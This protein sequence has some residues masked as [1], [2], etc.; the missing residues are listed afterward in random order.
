MRQDAEPFRSAN[1]SS[2]KYPRIV[3]EIVFEVES[4]FLT[5]HAGILDVPGVTIEA[6]LQDPAALSQNIVPD[7]ARSEIGSF[8]F[9]LVDIESVFTEAIRTRLLDDGYGLRGKLVR[10]FIGYATFEPGQIGS[11]AIPFGGNTFGS[12]V[13]GGT[14]IPTS[15]EALPASFDDFVVF[16]TQVITSVAYDAGVYKV[17]CADITRQQREIIFEP[18]ATTLLQPLT[19]SATSVEVAD[20]TDFQMIAHGTSYSD[21]P[22]SLVGYIKIDKEII[23][24]TSKTGGT[25]LGC[26]RGALNTKVVAHEFSSGTTEDR[27][28]KV[29]EYIY[30]E[31]PLVQIAYKI[32]TGKDPLTGLDCWP[33]HWNVGIDPD[34]VRISDFT[35]IGKDVWDITDANAAFVAF[36]QGL[37]KET[38]K[39]FLESEIYILLGCYSP[40]YADGTIG[41]KR[42]NQ[43]LADSAGVATLDEDNCVSWSELT[44]DYISMHNRIRLDWNFNG[45]DFTRN[46][47]FIDAASISIHGDAPVKV[48]R[49]KGLHGSRHTDA[50]VR[51]RIDAIRDRYSQPPQRMSVSVLPSLNI[52]EIGDIAKVKLSTVRDFAA[53][54]D[55]INRAF[56]IQQG[57]YNWANG[58]VSFTMF[59]STARASVLP[60]TSD[61]FVLPDAY[62]TDRGTN[63]TSVCTIVVTG[64]VGVIQAGSYT[65]TGNAD[66]NASAA[67]FYYDGN[68]QLQAGA[69]LTIIDNV[70][71]RHK[72]FF[73]INGTIN[74]VGHG[75]PGTTDA[76]YGA[77]YVLGTPGFIGNSRA[78][79]GIDI[80]PGDPPRGINI[81]VSATVGAYAAFPFVSL[82]IDGND[83]LGIPTDMRGT[84]CGAGG[85]ALYP[86]SVLGVPDPTS[87]FGGGAGGASGAG[88]TLVGRGMAIGGAGLINLSGGP[89]VQGAIATHMGYQLY[90]GAGGGGSPGG[91][92]ILVDGGSV[93]LPDIGGEFIA[94]VGHSPVI[95]N[96]LSSVGPIQ[97]EQFPATAHTSDTGPLS[98]IDLSNVA[99]RIQYI[100]ADQTPA[101]DVDILPATPKSLTVTGG[102]GGKITLSV[103]V[104]LIPGDR[105][106]FFASSTNDRTLSTLIGLGA[107]TEFVRAVPSG[108]TEY[109]WIRVRRVQPGVDTFSSF[110]PSSSTGGI[111][112]SAA[113]TVVTHFAQATNVVITQQAHVPVFV[114]D[115]I[116]VTFTPEVNCTLRCIVT[117][118]MSY[119]DGGSGFANMQLGVHASGNPTWV[120]NVSPPQVAGATTVM[121]FSQTQNISCTGGVST[122]IL[123]GASKLAGADTLTITSADLSVEELK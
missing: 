10:L 107:Q 72:G 56:E 79:D 103:E 104:D 63:L 121:T 101:P 45:T 83:L 100:P 109:Y 60:P 58:S 13:Y 74:G 96:Q 48:Y 15:N 52:L 64:G 106:E 85:Q 54:G 27:R 110:F 99:Y 66:M 50:F 46:T 97:I 11:A 47:L 24:Y 86:V 55:S 57:Q 67:I 36:F 62:Y 44:H 5:S 117:G 51:T 18:K 73:Q 32:L 118:V 37:T 31:E 38:G 8:S 116:S 22:S 21:S 69:T 49:F 61:S 33:E 34:L 28:P 113:A 71:I 70:Q 35:G 77:P 4:I 94:S 115:F 82:T 41:L 9:V 7:E 65:L 68:L 19:D 87:Y 112:A 114:T 122:T 30:I 89:G 93:S 2:V 91:L 23:K 43:V 40:V 95:G 26:T 80:L 12:G 102:I 25:F 1:A 3:V 59:G 90:P 88:L 14:L 120:Y 123:A 75:K 78:Q 39:Q 17:S 108:T 16:Q 81:Q 105:V 111:S 76:G 42:M 84:S 6:V 98:D 29:E 92:L 20:T 53:E 119:V